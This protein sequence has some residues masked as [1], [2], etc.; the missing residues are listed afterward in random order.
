M[1]IEKL[2]KKDILDLTE[3]IMGLDGIIPRISR[4]IKEVSVSY[5]AETSSN[6]VVFDDFDVRVIGTMFDK[7]TTKHKNAFKN[8]MHAKFGEEY[9][10]C[11]NE[12][13]NQKVQNESIK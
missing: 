8:F 6:Q 9:K 5:I 12:N 4:T 2:T 10:Q 3:Q 13:L 1:F 7:T 11:F